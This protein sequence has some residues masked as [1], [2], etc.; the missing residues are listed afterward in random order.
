MGFLKRIRGDDRSE[1]PDWADVLDP[2]E[3]KGFLDAVTQDL[4][5]RGLRAVIDDGYAVIDRG[6][7]E[8]YRFGLSNLVQTCHATERRDWPAVV[9]CSAYQVAAFTSKKRLRNAVWFS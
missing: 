3:Y 1:V 8:P 2:A 5:R 4:T 9:G 6:D 7:A